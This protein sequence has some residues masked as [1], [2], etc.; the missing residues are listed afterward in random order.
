M[1]KHA[2]PLLFAVFIGIASPLTSTTARADNLYVA[3]GTGD[4]ISQITPGGV[5]SIFVHGA[6]N[7]KGLAFDTAGNLYV[8][9][10]GNNTIEKFSSG[11]VDLGTFA[12][13]GLSN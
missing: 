1:K 13:T 5:L 9:N 7:P 6:H 3:N 8:G 2:P 4:T 11:G 12:S 10:A